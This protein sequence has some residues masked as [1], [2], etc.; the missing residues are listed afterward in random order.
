MPLSRADAKMEM[1]RITT[2]KLEIRSLKF[3][4]ITKFSKRHVRNSSPVRR[5]LFRLFRSFV[6]LNLF[7]ISTFGFRIFQSHLVHSCSGQNVR[8]MSRR[9]K[10]M[11][12]FTLIELLVVIVIIAVLIGLAFPVFQGVQNQAKRTQAR[13]DLMQIVTAVNAYFAEYGKYPHTP[14]TPGDTTYGAATTND[15][16]FNELRSVAATENPR[17]IV[18][19]SPPDAK[20]VNNPRAGISSAPATAGQYFDPWGKPYL[21]RIDTDYDNQV[22]NPYAQNAGSAPLLRSGVIAWSFGKD[23]LSQST[24]TL[25]VD[26]D[27]G[28]NKDDIISWQ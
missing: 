10:F 25:P 8:H 6:D 27:A 28:T 13:S 5:L 1:S 9:C 24:A 12:S 23:T 15:Q 2:E 16:L 7:R 26:K 21:I 19:L 22:N 4:T 18:F 20:D 11:A 14:P 17:G 3:E